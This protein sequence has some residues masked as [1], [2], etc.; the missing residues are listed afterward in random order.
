MGISEPAMTVVVIQLVQGSDI[1]RKSSELEE[2]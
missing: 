1:Y 2:I